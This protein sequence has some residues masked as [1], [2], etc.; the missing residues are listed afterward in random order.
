M[1]KEINPNGT[2]LKQLVKKRASNGLTIGGIYQVR[3]HPTSSA[4]YVYK[5]ESIIEVDNFV[6]AE[7]KE[8]FVDAVDLEALSL[9]KD[10]K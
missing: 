4:W 10:F 9:L 8:C 1:I 5:R 7:Y 6:T 3:Q 2:N